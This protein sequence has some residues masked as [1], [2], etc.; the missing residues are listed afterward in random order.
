MPQRTVLI[1]DPDATFAD[2]LRNLL[3]PY[4]LTCVTVD[5]GN[6]ALTR[7]RDLAPSLLI[8]CVELP[9]KP[10][11]YELLSTAKRSAT[12]RNVPIILTSHP[13]DAKA[14]QVF[15]EHNRLKNRANEYIFKTQF[16]HREFL[17][18]V[19]AILG[20][21]PIKE[22]SG[23]EEIEI[24]VETDVEMLEDIPMMSGINVIP[25]L[26]EVE[27]QPTRVGQGQSI[28]LGID[29]EADAAFAAIGA[30]A[31]A[32]AAAFDDKAFDD[33]GHTMSGAAPGFL[34]APLPEPEP[35]MEA[36]AEESGEMAVEAAPEPAHEPDLVEVA[37]EPDPEPEVEAELTPVEAQPPVA[38]PVRAA[39]LPDLDL[40]LDD[41]GTQVQQAFD[42][43]TPQATAAATRAVMATPAVGSPKAATPPP[44]QA[45]QPPPV[46]VAAL[47]PA[48][49]RELDEL[50][51]RAAD[52]ASE[53]ERLERELGEAK[54]RADKATA[55]S[56]VSKEREFLNLRETITRKDKD[57]RELKDE[58]G[59]KDRAILDIKDAVRNLESQNGEQDVK[60]LGL[61]REVVESHEKIDALTAD[62]EKATAREQQVKARLAD[63]QTEIKK[64]YDEIASWKQKLAK[65]ESDSKAELERTR[66][67]AAAAVKAAQDERDAQVKAAQGQAASDK[68]QLEA[69][70][71]QATEDAARRAQE[72]LRGEQDRS[73]GEVARLKR[74]SQEA[75]AAAEAARQAALA[76]AAERLD[77]AMAAANQQRVAELEAAAEAHAAD[78]A[79]L[80]DQHAAELQA[81]RDEHADALAAAEARRADELAAANKQRADELAAANKQRT[82]EVAAAEQRRE[83][84]LA[85][86]EQQRADEL[87]A[88]EKRRESELGNAMREAADA[89]A[90]AAAA[91]ASATAAALSAHSAEVEQLKADHTTA[92]LELEQKSEDEKA[93]IESR[94]STATEELRGK[95]AGEVAALQGEIAGHER[96]LAASRER[97]QALASDLENARRRGS[98]LDA[99]VAQ[100]QEAVAARDGSLRELGS[101][102][103]AVKEQ[104]AGYREQVVSAYSKIKSDEQLADKARKAMAV[105][106][107]L[108]DEQLRTANGAGSHEETP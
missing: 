20:I 105:A 45:T 37:P 92:L 38:E 61:E 57:I 77:A 15:R 108:L 95:H 12:T 44:R 93:G 72:A 81:L 43:P 11:G 79:A 34:P 9:G 107:T 17:T 28:D 26:E 82:D 103:S 13:A 2:R 46:A 39:E 67:E 73:A 74:E 10:S 90:A 78:R 3:E 66:S 41:V 94:W 1:V 36:V 104:N 58:L 22:P 65:L 85:A 24:P 100:L 33:A 42:P 70:H 19:D 64:T 7:A 8:I 5:N 60:I 84:E 62:K 35:E 54:A 71:R 18:K 86:A 51:L 23:M 50:R 59:K 98:E 102:L 88:A 53:R 76:A 14:E 29:A 106:L 83:R 52:W 40:G 31:G 16:D 21:G 49:G 56:P 55:G 89:A 91:H 32:A 68:A 80:V 47:D 99:A 75:L 27:D 101:E 6:E 69:D 63:A 97:I 25:V 48:L 30:D 96:D 87:A 4:E